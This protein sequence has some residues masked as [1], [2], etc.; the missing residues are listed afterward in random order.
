VV[1]S[2][3]ILVRAL[4]LLQEERL[5]L[6]HKNKINLAKVPAALNRVRPLVGYSIPRQRL[7]GLILSGCVAGCANTSLRRGRPKDEYVAAQFEN[8]SYYGIV[9]GLRGNLAHS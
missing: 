3:E 4:L 8:N 2:Q 1:A 5:E 6:M 7:C 9:D